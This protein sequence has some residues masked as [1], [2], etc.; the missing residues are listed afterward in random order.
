[1]V[2]DLWKKAELGSF[3]DRFQAKVE[4]HGVAMLKVAPQP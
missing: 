4:P 1:V 2:R 3:A